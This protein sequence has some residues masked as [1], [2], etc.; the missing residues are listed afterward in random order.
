MPW[1]LTE[2]LLKGTYL[3]L[4]VALALR[5]PTWPEVA[6]AAACTVGGL[7]LSLGSV[8]WAKIR[9]GY[10]I[11]GKVIG[12]TL[13]LLLDHPHKVYVGT[14]AGFAVGVLVAENEVSH[15]FL[16]YLEYFFAPVVGGVILGWF[17]SLLRHVR[18]RV[19]SWLG[20]A[21]TAIPI[22]AAGLLYLFPN[23][24]DDDQKQ[25]LGTVLLLGLPGFYLLTLAGLVEES[26]IDMAVMCGAL[27]AGLALI[28][29]SHTSD[30]TNPTFYFGTALFVP[31]LIY[32]FYTFLILPGLRVF[33]HALRGL[34]YAR[35]GE[36]RLALASL[37]RALSLNPRHSLAREQMWFVHRQMDVDQLKKDPETLA[38]I[39]Y[40]LC[41]ER[42]ATLLLLEKPQPAQLDEAER[43][44]H[45]VSDQRP[46]VEPTCAYW[47]AVAALHRRKIDD[48]ARDLE[49]VL[50]APADAAQVDWAQR[51]AI[52]Y[53]AWQ[54]AL[55]LH[56]EMKRRVGEPLLAQPARKLEAIAAVERR[57]AEK[58]EDPDAWEVKRLL[59][60]LLTEGDYAAVAGPGKIMSEFNHAYVQQLGLALIDKADEWQRG[61]EYLRLAARGLPLEAP[62][63]FIKIGKVYE[64]HGD[65]A[66]LWSNCQ[67]AIQSARAA[68]VANLK[69]EDRESLFTVVKELADQAM[70]QG[71]IDDALA[72]FKFYSQSERANKETYRTLAEL[73]ERKAEEARNE[74]KPEEA[75]ESVWLATHCTQHGLTY[76][77]ADKDLLERKDR[78]YYS[79]E[80]AEVRRRWESIHLWFDVD[81][82]IQKTR[83]LMER[84]Q[85][86][87]D[88]LDWAAHLA[89][90]AQQA[91]PHNL[92]ARLLRSRI[93]RARGEVAESIALLEEIRHNKPEK[94]A[95][96]EDADSWF[97]AHRLLGDAYLDD[98]PDQAVECLQ[99]FR[100]SERAGADTMYKLGRALE[101]L[102]DMK[103]AARC[104]EAVTAFEKHPLF[105]EARAAL[106]RVKRSN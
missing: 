38:L 24:L 53:Q 55:M 74:G 80:P 28:F 13:F 98:K 30:G 90:L 95:T 100:K 99:E 83:W 2:F 60:S 101:N 58:P 19:R 88:L 26:A 57:L 66:R 33:K 29:V 42:A 16:W 65:Q 105:Y 4:L 9:Q 17:F 67:I 49:I 92:T 86:N 25:K 21:L 102:G 70:T 61:C 77:A 47:R 94:F 71:K 93:R 1:H 22:V 97:V 45:L 8:A 85:S 41:L 37:N 36:H 56:P 69:A 44:L 54:L 46:A 18:T 106:E 31:L 12:F 87:L 59:Y 23:V 11:K 34:S 39:N 7:L 50:Q 89:E 96:E 52:L 10:R 79:I 76:D 104:Y 63:I 51:Q 91:Q 48:A 32:Y 20:L 40:D 14:I 15:D 43:L 78:Y 35:I 68:G 82:C 84:Y 62:A 64:A 73:F 72:L 3:G 27:G 5:K 103:R 75:Q 6:V 81:Y